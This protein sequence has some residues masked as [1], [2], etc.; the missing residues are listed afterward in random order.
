LEE[1]KSRDQG[2]GTRDQ[3]PGTRDKINATKYTKPQNPKTPFLKDNTNI[4]KL[5][6]ILINEELIVVNVA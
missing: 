2:P 1:N 6:L 5:N 4:K 3:G